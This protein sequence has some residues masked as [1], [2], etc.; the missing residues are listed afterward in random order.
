MGLAGRAQDPE[1]AV[2]RGDA[3]VERA[4]VPGSGEA[5]ELAE[6]VSGRTPVVAS[7]GTGRYENGPFL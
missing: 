4:G 2:G 1:R 3:A 6:A 5:N 7:R